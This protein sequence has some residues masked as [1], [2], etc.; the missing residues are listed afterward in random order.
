MVDLAQRALRKNTYRI[1][2]S[3][4]NYRDLAACLFE[5]EIISQGCYDS[6]TDDHTGKDNSS[7]LQD[8]IKNVN[9][10]I[11]SSPDNDVFSEF[12]KS[13]ES[14]GGLPEKE[15]AKK[16]R[17]THTGNVMTTFLLHR[18]FNGIMLYFCFIT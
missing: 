7:R 3:G 1:I 17:D 8:I 2:R 10:S 13:L 15:I 5:N 4:I 16:L 11:A 6:V 12:L 14:M 9:R 18:H